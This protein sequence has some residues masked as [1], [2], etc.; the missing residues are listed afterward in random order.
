MEQCSSS[1]DS[2]SVGGARVKAVSLDAVR[3]AGFGDMEVVSENVVPL[4]SCSM[5]RGIRSS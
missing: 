2:L 3:A 5:S 1:R 4:N